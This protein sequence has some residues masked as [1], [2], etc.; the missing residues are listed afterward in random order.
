MYVPCE[1]PRTSAG[2]CGH[3]PDS[4]LSKLCSIDSIMPRF[5]L[6]LSAME[7]LGSAHNES[8]ATTAILICRTRRYWPL[9]LARAAFEGTRQLAENLPDPFDAA[10]QRLSEP[11]RTRR[12][13][14][15][16]SHSRLS[17][18]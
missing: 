16:E 14:W 2:S 1:S 17:R 6:G 5:T 9:G 11:W 13:A 7:P 15:P 4:L 3:N 8:R 10:V 18:Q 12:I